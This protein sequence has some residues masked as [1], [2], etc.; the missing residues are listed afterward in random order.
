M[1]STQL[2]T[3]LDFVRARP[4]FRF[5]DM[6]EGI[7][8]SDSVI[9][10]IWQLLQFGRVSVAERLDDG[11][12]AFFSFKI[13]TFHRHASAT[14]K[15]T[16]ARCCHLGAATSVHVSTM[17]QSAQHSIVV[18][19]GFSDGGIADSSTTTQLE[20]ETQHCSRYGDGR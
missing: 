3:A 18:Q 11:T 14:A 7:D 1:F 5:L 6:V 10:S 15:A 9:S 17:S 2:D 4:T 16:S 13:P 19:K 12:V 8:S 20:P